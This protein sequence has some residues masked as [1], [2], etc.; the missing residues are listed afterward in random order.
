MKV[1]HSLGR[2]S[3]AKGIYIADLH[4]SY[5]QNS[6]PSCTTENRRCSRI[7]VFAFGHFTGPSPV[8]AYSSKCTG[9]NIFR[10]GY[11]SYPQVLNEILAEVERLL[12]HL[13]STE[14]ASEPTFLET[15]PYVDAT[16][17]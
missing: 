5:R 11:L 17:I 3:R 6:Q 12:A 1:F 15:L 2:G 10:S 14:E 4:A 9:L 13:T 7:L 16:T 8:T